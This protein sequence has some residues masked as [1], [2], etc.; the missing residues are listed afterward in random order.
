MIL[1][2][3]KI[4]MS[5]VLGKQHNKIRRRGIHTFY[6]SRKFKNIVATLL[7]IGFVMLLVYFLLKIKIPVNNDFGVRT[8]SS[9]I[10]LVGA[11]TL[12]EIKDKNIEFLNSVSGT[13]FGN[14]EANFS[15]IP[16]ISE[17]TDY[18]ELSAPVLISAEV[19][20]QAEAEDDI[21]D[22]PV[23]AV[24]EKN[25]ASENVK[26]KNET[27][28]NID[29]GALI[30]EKCD[31]TLNHKEPEILI[32]HTHGSE[33]YTQS[34]KYRYSPSDYARCQDTNFNVVRVGTELASELGKRGFN[35]LHDKS[36]NDYPSYN[37][38]YS[39]TLEVIEEY[40]NK[41]PTIKC[42]FDVHRDAVSDE[43]NGRVKFTAQI[44]GEK[45]SQVM[46]V[47]GTDQLGLENPNWQKNLATAL[48]IQFALEK[49]YPGFM[50]P[51]NLRKERFNL[52]KTTGSFIFEFGTHGNTLDEV[53]ASVKY[54]ADGIE[55]VLGQ[56][57]R[58]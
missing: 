3:G 39:K 38:S 36:I 37:H 54:F 55:D 19:T 30:D 45:V 20:E 1:Q 41:Y 22:L 33:S 11:G 24:V 16:L 53:L 43:E 26:M 25:V 8:L 9:A 14:P 7:C 10:P 21:S 23:V 51:L 35:V 42:V 18:K 40:L 48:K 49:R 13:S 15:V 34:E 52:H 4:V 46:I 6:I 32:V 44:N 50:R 12:D 27:T 29:T 57:G 56:K 31:I 28:Y 5:V 17:N 58:R 47:C 2:G